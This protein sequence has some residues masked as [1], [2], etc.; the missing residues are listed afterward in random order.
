MFGWVDGG[1]GVE[2]MGEERAFLEDEGIDRAVVKAPFGETGV[3][4]REGR[5][6]AGVADDE[7]DASVGPAT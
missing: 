2:L 7:V 1:W 5:G 4:R 3:A 6:F